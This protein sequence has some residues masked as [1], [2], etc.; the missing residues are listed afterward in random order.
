MNE[1]K[2]PEMGEF[3]KT[4]ESPKIT[5]EKLAIQI[6]LNWNALSE[7]FKKMFEQMSA[8]GHIESS[9]NM[10]ELA[11]E[12]MR[13]NALIFSPIEKK[14][15]KD[16]LQSITQGITLSDI[17]KR[18][19]LEANREQ[20]DFVTS[21][22]KIH[23]LKQ[24]PSEITLANFSHD[25]LKDFLTPID[26]TMI[27]E[28][29]QPYGI[30]ANMSMRQFYNLHTAWSVEILQKENTVKD[31]VSEKVIR[32]VARHHT[33][34]G[35]KVIDGELTLEDK[36]VIVLDQYDACRKRGGKTHKEAMGYIKKKIQKGKFKTDPEFKAL[37]AVL[38][39]A[40]HNTEAYK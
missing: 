15:R 13:D 20:S 10:N 4:E 25:Y 6:G 19:P 1:M 27:I 8:W 18:G 40:A 9:V 31:S 11:L 2:Q 21:V 17:G 28:S 12:V 7:G 34:D 22:F 37:L 24:N 3:K 14:L 38:E 30:T 5:A 33:L 35:V 32:M 29:L 39:N 26:R 36:I 23:N 16:V